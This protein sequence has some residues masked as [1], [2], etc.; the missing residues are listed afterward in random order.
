MSSH[1]VGD[2]FLNK[3]PPTNDGP[4]GNLFSYPL[5]NDGL[6]LYSPL[7]A[8]PAKP[9]SQSQRYQTLDPNTTPK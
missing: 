2:I 6:T 4:W 5:E 3:V 9:S 8:R 1:H 7:L